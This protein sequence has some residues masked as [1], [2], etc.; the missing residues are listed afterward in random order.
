MINKIILAFTLFFTLTSSYAQA[1]LNDYKYVIVPNKYDFLKEA[2]KYQLNSLT[3]F[4]FEKEGFTVI[5]QEDNY[6][7][8]M[9]NNRCLSLNSNVISSS[10]MFKTKLQV[11]LKDCNN[12]VVFESK[13]GETREK[14]YAKAHQLALRDAFT[15][16]NEVNYS[17]QPNETAI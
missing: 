9:Q 11:V 10:G 1:N 3:K 12:N 8:D 13:V 5:M 6:P 2:D 17:Y 4:L 16:F 7:K 14:D 15:S